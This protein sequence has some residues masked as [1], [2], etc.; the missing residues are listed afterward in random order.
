VQ[1][2]VPLSHYKKS[3]CGETPV[4]DLLVP[5]IASSAFTLAPWWATH[6]GDKLVIMRAAIA[7]HETA[8]DWVTLKLGSREVL[9]RVLEDRGR[10]GVQGRRL[11]RVLAVTA[12]PGLP[13]VVEL[14]EDELRP[15]SLITL[16]QAKEYADRYI[17]PKPF[18]KIRS[19]KYCVGTY[20]WPGGDGELCECADSFEEAIDQFR[21]RHPQMVVEPE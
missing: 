11:L 20:S 5:S 3:E 4:R 21:R 16:P 19:G 1:E 14:P 8:P 18:A 12:G 17:V 15:A 13:G 10:I 6:R 9:G 2:R 7:H